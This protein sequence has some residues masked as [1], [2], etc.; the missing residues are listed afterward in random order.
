MLIV[1]TNRMAEAHQQDA[2]GDDEPES[3]DDKLATHVERIRSVLAIE[4]RD[5]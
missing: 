3:F 2:T 5:E 4:P 1:T